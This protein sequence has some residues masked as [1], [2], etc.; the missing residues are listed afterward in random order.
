MVFIAGRVGKKGGKL[1]VGDCRLEEEIKLNEN[2][3]CGVYPI[4][5]W[6]ALNCLPPAVWESQGRPGCPPFQMLEYQQL[7]LS[8]FCFRRRFGTVLFRCEPPLCISHKF[9][10]LAAPGCHSI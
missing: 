1:L 2:D 10:S 6:M 8:F 3:K 5:G 9:Q 4:F 7:F